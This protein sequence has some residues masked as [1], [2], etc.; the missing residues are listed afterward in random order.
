[1]EP[2]AP[3]SHLRGR[4]RGP[5]PATPFLER[6]GLMWEPQPHRPGPALSPIPTRTRR[7]G[8]PHVLA[9]PRVARS[10]HS[11]P[12]KRAAGAESS[13]DLTGIKSGP[14]KTLPRLR[15]FLRAPTFSAPAS[16]FL[17]G[18]RASSRGNRGNGR[19]ARSRVTQQGRQDLNL[20][21]PVLETGALPIELRPWVGA[22]CIGGLA[23][24]LQPWRRLR[25]G[26]L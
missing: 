7:S 18:Q 8:R 1:M 17:T 22:D 24:T 19:A 9:L 6:A 20:Q 4:G 5:Q 12:R 2:S 11:I 23:D 16:P 25:S 14:R 21:P 15:H 3:T 13:P 10:A 26:T